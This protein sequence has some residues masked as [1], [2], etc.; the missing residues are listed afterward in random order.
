MKF[1]STPTAD[2]EDPESILLVDIARCGGHDIEA[3]HKSQA[4]VR[5]NLILQDPPPTNDNIK[6]HDL[7]TVRQEYDLFLH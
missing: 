7:G 5:G 6:S 1:F 3:L 2:K 4:D